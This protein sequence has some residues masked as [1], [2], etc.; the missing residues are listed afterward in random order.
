MSDSPTSEFRPTSCGL[1]EH[2]AYFK[3]RTEDAQW[4][5]S[6]TTLAVVVSKPECAPPDSCPLPVDP[7]AAATTEQV[8]AKTLGITDV[9][10]FNRRSRLAE[11][12]QAVEDA[13]EVVAR[14]E[15][16]TRVLSSD[17]KAVLNMRQ[18][19][20]AEAD[21]K[22]TADTV[23]AAMDLHNMKTQISDLSR[24]LEDMQDEVEHSH[25][26]IDGLLAALKV[27]AR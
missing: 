21:A 13:A 25:R 6:K 15:M 27:I 11:H 10:E 1:C 12:A 14:A 3:A 9:A 22:L 16:Y 18:R 5:C 7:A 24:R 17:P 19:A 26:V 8:M 20:A 23:A 4:R 2:A